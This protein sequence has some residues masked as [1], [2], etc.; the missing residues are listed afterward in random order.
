MQKWKERDENIE[1]INFV[2]TD[3]WVVWHYIEQYI[4][5]FSA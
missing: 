2:T 1:A 5:D 4:A 3:D